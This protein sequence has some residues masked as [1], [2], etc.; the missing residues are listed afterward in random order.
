[1]SSR[2]HGRGALFDAEPAG[3]VPR[4][5]GVRPHELRAVEP[6]ECASQEE[7]P[8]L[9]LSGGRGM[10]KTAVLQETFSAYQVTRPGRQLRHTPLA[11]IDCEQEAFARPRP[12]QAPEAWSPVS[13]ALLMLAEQLGERVKHAGEVV[14]P[15]LMAGLVA[16]AA[17]GWRDADAERIRRELSRILL[18]NEGGAGITG[19]AGRW[20]G[21][22]VSKVIAATSGQAPFVAAAIEATLES[23]TE[24][25]AGRRR[26]KSST[27]YRTYP[28]AGGNAQRGLILLSQ[29][30]RAGS[31]SRE[32]AERRLVRAL[33]ADL[34]EAYTGLGSR[35]RRLGRPLI[36]LDNAHTGPGPGL[37]EAVLRDRAEGFADEVAFVVAVRGPDHPVLH[38]APRLELAEVARRTDWRPDTSPAS[39]AL[40]VPLPRLS[41]DDTLHIV[42]AVCETA[43]TPAELPRATHRLT[44]G[45]P[46]GIDLLAEAARQHPQ[47]ADS[48]GRLLVTPLAGERGPG[49]AR[50]VY[51]A[52]LEKLVPGDRLEELTVLAA[53]HDLESAVALADARLPADFGS[54]GVR[55]LQARLAAEGLPSVPGHFAGDPFVR[56]LLLLRLH[57]GQDGHGKWREVHETLIAHYSPDGDADSPGDPAQARHRLHHEL[58]L[59]DTSG[60]VAHLRDTFSTL[61]ARIWLDTLCF[62]A[63]APYFHAHDEDGRDFDRPDDRRAATALDHAGTRQPAPEGTDPVLHQRV[64][65]LLHAAW[66]LSDPLVLPDERVCERMRFELLQL[67]DLREEGGAL[68]WQAAQEW[69]RDARAGRPLRTP[70]DETDDPDGEA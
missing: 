39:R 28:N 44:G 56:T 25:F 55:T 58:C 26:Q 27:W 48:L 11:L 9:V 57:D 52:L 59:G 47:R 54:A 5:V 42:G 14:F 15:R 24:G 6:Q 20:A 7:L 49:E 21:R 1:M 2:L 23:V 50:P 66:Q 37:M 19:L 38:G 12:E 68:L 69:P 29:H 61:D 51:S 53:A 65:R 4:L 46:L 60:A 16:V 67:C 36:L 34:T 62:L 45:N 35:L 33:L 3:L 63:A 30:F 64:R 17:S 40:V 70:K 10:G 8:L 41:A 31:P 32:H 18:L 13:Q 22:V 43:G